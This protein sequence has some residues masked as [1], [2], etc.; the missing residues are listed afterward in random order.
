[1]ML[2]VGASMGEIASAYPTSGA[3]YFSAGPGLSVW[4]ARRAVG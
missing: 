2:F 1:M 3:L 4:T